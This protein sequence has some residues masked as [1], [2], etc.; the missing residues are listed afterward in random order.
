MDFRLSSRS[1][2]STV[3]QTTHVCVHENLHATT[4]PLNCFLVNQLFIHLGPLGFCQQKPV[5]ATQ[6]GR[7]SRGEG[8]GDRDAS[9]RIVRH[10]SSISAID[11]N[12]S[13]AMPP[14]LWTAKKS[15]IWQK[16]NLRKVAPVIL[17]ID[18]ISIMHKKKHNSIAL[19]IME[20]RPS[21]PVI[22]WCAYLFNIYNLHRYIL[23]H[24]RHL[25]I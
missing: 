25:H 8:E 16:C 11:N 13:R 9:T 10:L 21:S 12:Y 6:H 18:I 19:N 2:I 5:T 24:V 22:Q 20:K 4:S 3:Q 23:Y 7:R 15:R 14:P 1:D 17:H